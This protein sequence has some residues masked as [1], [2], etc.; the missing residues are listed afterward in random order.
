MPDAVAHEGHPALHEEGAD[1][2]GGGADEDRGD[3]ARCMRGELSSSTTWSHAVTGSPPRTATDRCAA[4]RGRGAR[5]CGRATAPACSPRA[6]GGAPSCTTRPWRSTTARSISGAN[7][8]SSCRITTTV[9]PASR[10]RLTVVDEG[11]LA[12]GCRCRD[13]GSSS[14][15]RSGSR[16]SAR[17]MSTRCCCPPDSSCTALVRPVAPG[18]RPSSA[19]SARAPAPARRPQ[20]AAVQQPGRRRPRRRSRGRPRRRARAAAR[21]R[22]G[23]TGPTGRAARRTAGPSP[24]VRRHDAEQRAHE[25][26]LA[27]AVGAEQRERPRPR[28]TARSMPPRIG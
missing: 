19:A 23:P 5:A 11:R 22:C 10:R 14:T 28:A 20:R 6:R 15:S 18:R 17:A 8:P 12:S 7:G 26:R 3:S 21:S 2:G 25:G 1:D 4:A 9:V 16:T 27:G 24:G 13:V